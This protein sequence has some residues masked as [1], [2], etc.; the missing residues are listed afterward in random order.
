MGVSLRYKH[1]TTHLN[2]GSF[3]QLSVATAA[4]KE[5]DESLK[6]LLKRN[7]SKIDL[8]EKKTKTIVDT[9]IQE[10]R[11]KHDALSK[12]SKKWEMSEIEKII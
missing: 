6:D 5:L 2:V 11:N 12:K 8:G 4:V 1:F 7:E 10:V 9:A 3:K